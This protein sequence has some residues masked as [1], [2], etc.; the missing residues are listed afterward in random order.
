MVGLVDVVVNVDEPEFETI[1]EKI[2]VVPAPEL[3]TVGGLNGSRWK[4]PASG[5]VP[6]TPVGP[7]PTA[8]P[9]CVLP[10]CPYTE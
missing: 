1:V 10:G 3:L 5:V 4:I 7:A 6:V 8:H 9:S 2:V